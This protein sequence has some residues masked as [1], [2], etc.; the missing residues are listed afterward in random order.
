MPCIKIDKPQVVD[1]FSEKVMQKRDFEVIFM[2]YD[3]NNG[4]Y[5]RATVLLCIGIY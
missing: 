4:S 5:I 3:K 1:R 2:P